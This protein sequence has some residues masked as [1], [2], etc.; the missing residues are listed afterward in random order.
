MI[1]RSE[2]ALLLA[3]YFHTSVALE[4]RVCCG[5]EATDLCKEQVADASQDKCG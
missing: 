5:N 3:Q 2:L 1:F 4:Q